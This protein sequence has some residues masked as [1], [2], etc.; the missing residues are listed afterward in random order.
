MKTTA[1]RELKIELPDDERGLNPGQ[2]VRFDK[3]KRRLLR[4]D[5]KPA[6]REAALAELHSLET[7]PREIRERSALDAGIAQAVAM[8]EA[9][10]AQVEREKARIRVTSHDG[11][12]SLYLVRKLTQEQYDCGLVF[13]RG[14]V[15]RSADLS[16]QP[17]GEGTGGGHQHE[18]FVA[19]RAERAFALQWLGKVTV[20][21]ALHARPNALAML[22]RVAG[23]GMALSVF[24]KGRAFERNLA[25]LCRA[26]D[27]CAGVSTRNRT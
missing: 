4:A 7:G 6:Q 10:G 14:W 18:G 15:S 5:L 8:A 16:S 25:D 19:S 22:Q 11:L 3:L 2:V 21:V 24:G 26:L 27:L 12:H 1:V 9:R 23:D 13:R 17:P 20:H